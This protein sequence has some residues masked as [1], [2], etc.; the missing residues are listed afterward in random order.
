[1]E[2]DIINILRRQDTDLKT[3]IKLL[4]ERIEIENNELVID[5]IS[6]LIKE[7]KIFLNGRNKYSLVTNEHIIAPL[8]SCSK[9]L[10][11]VKFNRDKI[12]IYPENTHTAL[13]NDLVVVEPTTCNTGKVVGIINRKNNKLV[14]EVK[15]K[16]N[17]LKLVPFN[18]NKEISIIADKELLK[19]LIEGDRVY[20]ELDNK[21]DFDNEI[22]VKNIVKLGHF[23][24][25]LND[26]IAIAISKDFDIDFSDETI[27]EVKKI[28][29]EV[30][31]EETKDRLDLR[32][33]NIFTIDSIS[34]KDMDDAISIKKLYNGNYLLSV[35]IADVSHYL[36]IG[37]P[38]FKEASNRGTSVYLGEKV[39][40]MIPSELSN[41]IC[42]LNEDVDRLTK[43]VIM[44]INLKGKVV[45]SKLVNSVIHSKK[46]MTY[47]DLN[48]LFDGGEVDASYYPFLN[49]LK[50]LVELSDILSKNKKNRGHLIFESSD[51]KVNFDDED[52]PIDF[53]HRKIGIA[54]KIIE[55]CMVV[56]NET[57]ADYFYW[58]E[59]PFVY[60]VHNNPDELKLEDTM[61]LISNLGYKLVRLQNAYGQKAIQNILNDYKDKPEYTII[62]NLLLRN[63]SKAKYS[64]HNI[65]HYALASDTYCHFT[66]P[67]RRFPDLMVHTLINIFINNDYEYNH[68][69]VKKFINNLDEMCE[70]SS[71]KERQSDKAERDYIKLKMAEY[72]SNHINEEFEGIILD[73]DKENVYIKLN[74]NIKGILDLESSFMDAF[75]VDTYKRQ[76][77]SKYSKQEVHLGTKI[78]VTVTKVDIPQ[79]EVYF[80]IKEIIK[81]HDNKHTKK[82]ELTKND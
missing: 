56:A 70:H 63:M 76:L 43:S 3:I 59:L 73:I 41:G 4:E 20:I 9:E 21:I 13:I 66:S 48:T 2:T 42:S 27:E 61:E 53:E 54:Q 39:I 64:T 26:E 7:Q 19:D 71:Y 55:D 58:R 29:M 18:G 10:K 30:S 6:N 77:K 37:S 15:I 52:K 16:N 1:M 72:M 69:E 81:N 11:Y 8:Q 49:D 57:V 44:E 14:C 34:T 23:N 68:K 62:S 50:L 38:I 74:N 47:E 25:K 17:Q 60:R 78:I 28:P 12:I 80:D 51:I 79:K 35:H 36:P 65:G 45:K 33:E 31:I 40:P 67:I 75:D 82:L 32:D 22:L 5:A 46:K 24:D